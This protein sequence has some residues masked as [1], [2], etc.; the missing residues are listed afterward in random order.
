MGVVP[1]GTATTAS[2]RCIA[3]AAAVASSSRDAFAIGSAV[4]SETIVWK[5]SNASSRPCAISGW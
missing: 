3:S 1:G 4:K 2:V 5:L